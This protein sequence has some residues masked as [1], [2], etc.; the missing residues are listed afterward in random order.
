[1]ERREFF[2]SLIAGGASM[3]ER[4][5]AKNRR[6]HHTGERLY[7]G[8]MEIPEDIV[9]IIAAHPAI[10]K[11]TCRHLV[12]RYANT[13]WVWLFRCQIPESRQMVGEIIR[14]PEGKIRVHCWSAARSNGLSIKTPADIIAGVDARKLRDSIC[15][16]DDPRW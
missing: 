8:P 15:L 2:K 13:G 3:R 6:A 14:T 4:P 1:M 12:S 16:E 7:H 5:R 11:T 9:R 10:K